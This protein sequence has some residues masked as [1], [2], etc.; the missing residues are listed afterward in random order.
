MALASIQLCHIDPIDRAA[1]KFQ[2]TVHHEGDNMQALF[3]CSSERDAI[4][5]RNAI[6]EHAD[7]LSDVFDFRERFKA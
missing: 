4:A 3:T 6:R 7:C 5:L 2:V 1:G